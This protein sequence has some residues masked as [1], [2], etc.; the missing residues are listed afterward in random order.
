MDRKERIHDLRE[1]LIAT[2]QG[3]QADMWS[4][5]PGIVQSVDLVKQ[6][7]VVQIAIQMAVQDITTGTTQL[8][9]VSPLL[10]C[11]LFFPHGGN[12]SITFP[13]AAGDECLVVF[14]SRCID[15]WWQNGGVQPQAIFR[16]HDL[17]DGF[18]FV[19]FRS[20]G[21]VVGS[22]SATKL[23]IRSADGDNVIE[24]DPTGAQINVR[25][26]TLVTVA[27]PAII[28]Q[29]TTT[30]QGSLSVTAGV[31]IGV[32]L[33]VGTDITTGTL[34]VGG[35]PFASHIHSG[36]TTGIHDSGPPV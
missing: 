20:N 1:T 29:G 15:G 23:Q 25:A 35:R 2:L 36:V 28:L 4:S 18:A 3:W 7:C 19:G 33:A 30:I 26:G 10:D 21:N 17:S 11:P 32:G 34:E 31:E 14:A 13:V 6:T 16:M 5:M 24:V 9:S 12:M 27:A 8:Q 22:I